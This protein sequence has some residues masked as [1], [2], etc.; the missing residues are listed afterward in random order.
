VKPGFAEPK[1]LRR[2]VERHLTFQ[3]LEDAPWPI[4]V[5]AT[6]V[7][8][9]QEVQLSHGPAVDAVMASAALPAV[10]PPA[11]IDDHI[12]ME[13]G[14][15]NNTP[16]SAAIDLGADLIYVL[17]TG[18]ACALAAAPRSTIGMALHAVTLAIQQRLI[19]DVQTFQQQLQLRVAPPLCP[20]SGSPVDFGHTAELIRRARVSTN[21]WLDKPMA[22][23]QSRQLHLHP[24]HRQES[25]IE[26]HHDNPAAFASHR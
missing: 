3:R 15:V 21:A 22:P 8:T 2:L 4:T 11:S 26:D 23:C 10:F 12:L 7:I 14:V 18:Y 13:G 16:I 5:V 24:H 19:A 6:D 20:L 25:S 1:P 9:G 17:P